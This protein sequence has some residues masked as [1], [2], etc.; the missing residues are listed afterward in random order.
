M[1]PS[2]ATLLLFDRYPETPGAKSTLDTSRGAAVEMRSWARTLRDDCLAFIKRHESTADEV[3][4]FLGE[5][6]L[7]VRPRISE[8]HAKGLIRDSLKRRRNSSGKS[9]VVWEAI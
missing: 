2:T 9:A 7:A 8:L 6:V 4:V 3:A 1:H 5:S